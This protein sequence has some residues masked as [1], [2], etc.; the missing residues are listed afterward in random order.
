[1][2]IDVSSTFPHLPRQ[3][4]RPE[5][6]KRANP[7][8]TRNN[9]PT[10]RHSAMLTSMTSL[11]ALTQGNHA[12]APFNATFYAT[13]ATVIP[14]LFLAVAVQGPIYANVLKTIHRMDPNKHRATMRRWP[15]TLVIG[16]AYIFLFGVLFAVLIPILGVLGEIDALVSLAAQHAVGTQ[17][18]VLF[19]ALLLLLM[20]GVG[21]I[22]AWW[23]SLPSSF[24]RYQPRDRKSE[25]SGETANAPD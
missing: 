7:A 2:I 20:A 14:V 13:V 15:F 4:S 21:P 22:A 24:E 19:S 5:F 23:E 17:G 18:G 11:T 8:L 16:A 6:W 25:S 12:A 9:L 10:V 3:E 1:M